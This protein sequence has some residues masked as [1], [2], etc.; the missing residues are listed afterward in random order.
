MKPFLAICL[1]LLTAHVLVKYVIFSYQTPD[2]K[3]LKQGLIQSL[4][5]GGISYL[6]LGILSAW[7]IVLGVILS[8]LIF[9]FLFRKEQRY[10]CPSFLW[11][12]ALQVSILLVFSWA[13]SSPYGPQHSLWMRWIGEGYYDLMLWIL[14]GLCVLYVGDAIV[15]CG[16]EPYYA[17]IESYR[18]K[19]EE[20]FDRDEVG[21]PR[22]LRAGGKIIGQL[23]RSLIY[24]FVLVDQP[25]AV[26]FLIAAKS[27]FRFGEL[28]RSENRMEAEYII[29]GTLLSFLCGLSISYLVVYIS[30][31]M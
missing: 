1:P 26:G 22:G 14:G 2:R 21:F 19:D 3:P 12:Q 11:E 4:L 16:V 28:M 17:Q 24:L 13:A 10:A 27:I 23:E 5:V 31:L 9:S 6:I 15:S 20:G 7:N 18:G 8:T 29:I 30:S 25:Q